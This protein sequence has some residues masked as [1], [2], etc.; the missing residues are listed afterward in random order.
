[1]SIFLTFIQFAYR[2]SNDMYFKID[3]S[4]LQIRISV[5]LYAKALTGN[6]VRWKKKVPDS[7]TG[8]LYSDID[9]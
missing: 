4:K 9:I 2:N 1:M 6:N 8:Y 7:H 3:L 5:V